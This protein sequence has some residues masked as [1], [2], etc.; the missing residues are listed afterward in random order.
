LPRKSYYINI[1]FDEDIVGTVYCSGFGA[2]VSK[3]RKGL[4]PIAN[5]G[6]QQRHTTMQ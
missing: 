1:S 5:G 4:Q 2:R 3:P 6:M